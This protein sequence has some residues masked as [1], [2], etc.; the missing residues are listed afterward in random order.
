M[1]IQRVILKNYRNYRDLNVQLNK[2]IN[3]FYGQNAQGKTNI[4]ESIC[5]AST[6]KS[7]RT[8][9]DAELI[10]WNS[11]DSRVKIEFEKEKDNKTVEIYLKKGFKKQVKLNG[12]RLN[13][14]GELIGNLNTVVFSPDHMKIIKDGPSERRRFIDIILSQVK[15]G[16]YYNLVQ[17]LKV[18]EQRNILL[19]EAKKNI[20]AIRTMDIWNEQLVLYGTKIIKARDEFIKN[21][22]IFAAET[23]ERISNRKEKLEMIYKPSVEAYEGNEK[24]I[25]KR[26]TEYL[27]RFRD[28]DLKR[29]IT[30]KGP[31]R[32][33][34]FLYL[35]NMEVKTY[36][37]QGQ[38]RTTLLSIKISEL[39]Y[40]SKETEE[41]PILLLDDVFSELDMERQKYLMEFIKG[42]QTVIT[43]TDI[44]HM[45]KLKINDTK[46]FK[47]IN[48]TVFEY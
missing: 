8:Q 12:V 29:G 25:E 5:L 26:Y 15:P 11:E 13:K 14:I 40:M 44:E 4:I 16:Y 23:H 34:L 7:H 45:D 3:I 20:K 37:S 30:H 21:I 46:L 2:G 24:A 6:G 22:N 9:K 17:Y 31:H 36:C 1:Y 48:G 32:D 18:L 33:D 43:C 42:V 47:V 35:N 39:K 41:V 10:N 28:E 27:E 19:N 38:Q